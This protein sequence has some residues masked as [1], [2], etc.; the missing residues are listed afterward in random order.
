MK[1]VFVAS[2]FRGVEDAVGYAKRCMLDSIRRGEA[3]FASHLLYPLVLSENDE[4]RKLGMECGKAFLCRCNL[5]AVYVD[6]GISEGMEE[7]I[8]EADKVY[9]TITYRKIGP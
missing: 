6:H 9:M 7:E 2:P 3:P 4:E 8:E 1:L 5:L